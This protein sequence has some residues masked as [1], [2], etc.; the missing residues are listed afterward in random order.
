MNVVQRDLDVPSSSVPKKYDRTSNVAEFRSRRHRPPPPP[1]Q[2][3]V[4]TED[5]HVYICMYDSHCDIVILVGLHVMLVVRKN[6]NIYMLK[7]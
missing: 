7:I 2:S 4:G 1:P 5:I 6:Y 3:N